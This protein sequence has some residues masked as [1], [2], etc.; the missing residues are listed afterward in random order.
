MDFF[1]YPLLSE[2]RLLREA[3]S[4]TA[5]NDAVLEERAEKI[6]TSVSI[7]KKENDSRTICCSRSGFR[8]PRLD[9]LIPA[10][11]IDTMSALTHG[12]E[13]NPV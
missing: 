2:Y 3:L 9:C 8:L 13:H 10:S 11:D 7:S 6:K 5:V 1:T 4:G 12:I